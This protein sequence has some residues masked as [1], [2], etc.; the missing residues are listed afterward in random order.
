[1]MSLTTTCPSGQTSRTQA[2]HGASKCLWC[3]VATILLLHAALLCRLCFV[4]SPNLDELAHLPAGI[5]HWELGRFDL[6]RVNPPLVR[7]VAAV[8]I[9]FSHATRDWSDYKD[10]LNSRP[11]F[12]VGKSFV[13]NNQY[14]TFRYFSIAR[15]ACMPFSLLGCLVAFCWA[16]ELYGWRS[17]LIALFLYAF[18]P[19]MLTWGASITPDAAAAST[20]LLAM[21]TFRRWLRRATWSSACTAGGC[22]GIALLTKSIWLFLLIVFPTL[23][24]IAQLSKAPQ[25]ETVGMGQ[26]WQG[27]TI[28]LIGCYVL[29]LGYMFEGT[30]SQLGSFRFIS[31]TLPAQDS[32]QYGA[33]RFVGTPFAMIPVPFPTNYVRGIDVQKRDFERGKWSYLRG[34]QKPGGWW[35]YYLYAFAVKSTLGF[36]GL[37]AFATLSCLRAPSR[38]S[39]DECLLVMAAVFVFV[40]VS[41]QTGFNRYYR[42]VLPAL[43]FL[44]VFSSRTLGGHALCSRRG[45][46]VCGLVLAAALESLAAFPHSL[47]FFNLAAGGPLDGPNHLLDANIDWGQDLKKLKCWSDQHP[48][49]RP[50]HVAYFAEWDIAPQIAGIDCL[51]VPAHE[52]LDHPP[53]QLEPGWYAVSVNYV[54]GLHYF[55]DD[56]PKYA[57]FKKMTPADYVGYSIY[58]YRVE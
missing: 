6:Y 31:K 50:L 20:G 25:A 47:S 41:S 13:K 27:A 35:Y 55:D 33:N 36:L 5:S 15:L 38:F 9:L 14:Q 43:P 32:P 3:I 49:A 22:L 34:E 4:N 57:Y 48:G 21:W 24:L 52:D 56:I 46:F 51:E 28:L 17:G 7:L 54:Y 23:L 42:Y 18:S 29:N 30:F 10:A 39:F 58:V 45:C 12:F 11:E 40:L 2:I 26:R 16:R 53:P 8:P 44:F 37:L 19:N 1:M